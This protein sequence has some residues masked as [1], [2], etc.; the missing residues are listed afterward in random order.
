MSAE[1]LIKHDVAPA[2]PPAG[3]NTIYTKTDG[4][5]YH[6]NPA[7]V[8]SLV[9]VVSNAEVFTNKTFNL[10]DN[11]LIATSLQLKT[12]LT[13]ETG[14]GAAVFANSPALI[15]PTGIVKN[16]V[17][18]GNVDNTSDENKP[19]SIAQ[20][21]ANVA[22]RAYADTLV[23]GLVDDRGNFNASINAYPSTGGSGAAGAILK[24]DLWTVSV[25]GTLPTSQVVTAGDLVRALVDTPGNTQA[26]WAVTENNIGYVAENS[27]NK[28][29]S[30]SGASTDTQYPTAKLA[31]DQLALKQDTV[32]AGA[33]LTKTGV[34]IDIV[35]TANRIVVAADAIDI[36]TD[37]VT[38]TASQTLTNKTLTAPLGIVKGDVGLGSVDNTSDVDKPVSTLQRAATQNSAD[39]YLTSVAGTANAITAALTPA[40]LAAVQGQKFHFVAALANTGATAIVINAL[41]SASITKNGTNA[42]I[43]DDILAG[44][45]YVIIRDATGNFQ[46]SG[47][48]G[49]G[50]GTS[51]RGGAVAVNLQTLTG[52]VVLATGES[53]SAVGPLNGGGFSVTGTGTA[54]FIVL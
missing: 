44:G 39:R 38:L 19:V 49:G 54:R 18:L 20:A 22:D 52:N 31:F 16:D 40:L 36:G 1:I 11:T 17:G 13:D 48:A 42:L 3:W 8:E 43:A 5:M 7:G 32:I 21:A 37:V 14:S 35:G 45:A 23:V 27:A 15:T 28:V 33:G 29:T 25:A 53:G 46:L 12:A 24:G 26:N 47:G 41:A 50:G 34:T 2:A 4:R 9:S 10:T 30:I 51:L 6:K